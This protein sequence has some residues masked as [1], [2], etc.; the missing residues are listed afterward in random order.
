M[1][2]LL[3]SMVLALALSCAGENKQIANTRDDNKRQTIPKLSV[4]EQKRYES[5]VRSL[6]PQLWT[7]D[8]SQLQI[9]IYHHDI[10]DLDHSRYVCASM[11]NKEG[12]CKIRFDRANDDK[13]ISLYNT[14]YSKM[15][16][17]YYFPPKHITLDAA[18]KRA[19]EVSNM[20]GVSNIWDQ[21]S[22]TVQF[23]ELVYGV[24]SFS[25][26]AK[27]NGYPSLY[28]VSCCIADD[29]EMNIYRWGTTI[30][31]IPFDLGTNVV[32]S[33]AEG[34]AKGT[35]YLRK[36]YPDNEAAGKASFITNK[37]EYITPNYHY[38]RDDGLDEFYDGG[39]TNRPVLTWVN[40]FKSNTGSKYDRH[41]P[42]IIYVDAETGAMLGGM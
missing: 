25:L 6:I 13:L 32:L 27:V 18:K 35:E 30:H 12:G 23:A 31:D 28:G 37:V 5:K 9:S 34:C 7:N 8:Y 33:A 26:T 40:Y 41:F 3:F 16:E 15:S 36:Y 17:Q 1:K 2:S 10:S 4:K 42:I 20:F 22:Y 19:E 11:R 29:P 24:W 38:I 21:A 39:H 14:Q